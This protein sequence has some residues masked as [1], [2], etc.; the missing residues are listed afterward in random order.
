[1]SSTIALLRSVRAVNQRTALMHKSQIRCSAAAPGPNTTNGTS[2]IEPPNIHRLA[3]LAQ[4]GVSE[5]EAAE[6]GPKI[7][8]IVEWFGQLQQVDL[9]GV[10]PSLR[11]DVGDDTVLRPD[12]QQDFPER[13][14]LVHLFLFY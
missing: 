6:W 3:Q 7:S 11:A 8:S 9:E 12:Q 5:Q 10:P 13:C 14:V 1:M 2:D 4:V